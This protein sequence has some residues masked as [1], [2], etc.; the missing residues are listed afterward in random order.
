MK[1]K[2]HAAT[3]C[4]VLLTVSAHSAVIVNY[5]MTGAATPS[6]PINL[7]PTEFNPSVTATS[8]TNQAGGA[9]TGGF[10]YAGNNL[11]SSWGVAVGA[12][13]TTFAA[14]IANGNF[15]QF[16]VSPVAGQQINLTNITFRAAIGTTS[17]TSNRAFFLASETA[18]A[19]FTNASTV[20]RTDRSTGG[21]GGIAS[22]A[23]PVGNTVMTAYD[24][25]LSSLPAITGTRFFR[26]YTQAPDI[27]QALTFDDIVVNGTVSPIPEPSSAA[28]LAGG[29]LLA[30]ARRRRNS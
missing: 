12:T 26:L 5:A 14:A 7:A 21:G 17:T 11:A 20:L 22:Q 2:I 6:G 27:G 15:V 18:T 4:S 1:N 25:S 8:L 13:G 28:L 16:S 9:T 30:A 10:N 24:V 3:I 23:S 19:S 29:L